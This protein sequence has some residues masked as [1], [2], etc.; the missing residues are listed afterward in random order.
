M[1][2]GVFLAIRMPNVAVILVGL[3]THISI[4]NLMLCEW[5]SPSCRRDAPLVRR[6]FVAKPW[7]LRRSNSE[8]RM[9]KE[10]IGRGV[11]ASKL[12]E[13]LRSSGAPTHGQNGIAEAHSGLLHL[14]LIVETSLLEGSKT[15]GTQHLRTHTTRQV[16]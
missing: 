8:A 11:A 15:V 2:G 5:L 12:L 9:A 1:M 13:H 6:I 14:V 7:P 10:R 3:R 16:T 4:E